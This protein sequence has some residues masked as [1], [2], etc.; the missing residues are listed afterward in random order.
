MD[1]S[2]QIDVF[3]PTYNSEA[4]LRDC[5]SSVRRAFPVR[6]IVLVDHH[7]TD[8]TLEIANANA[9]EVVQEAS[10]LGYARQLAVEMSE[11]EV[12]AMVES[13]LV[14]EEF[15]WYSEALR[16]L[17][18]SV[19]AVVAYVPRPASDERGMYSEFWSRRTPLRARRHGFSAGSTLFR[20]QAVAGIRLPTNLNAYED[21]FLMRQMRKRGWTY[22]TMEVRGTHYSDYESSRK[23]RWYGANARLLYSLEPGDLTLLRRQVTLPL[24]GLIAAL[25]LGSASVFAWSLRFSANFLLGWGRPKK[26]SELKR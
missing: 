21:I 13:D 23:A 17:E 20:R 18:G 24:L 11:T 16:R 1:P 9:C 10:G 6:R 22:S 7:S 12:L 3:I 15:D 26:F 5:I 8:G 14:Y 4:H 25:G 19:G 2:A